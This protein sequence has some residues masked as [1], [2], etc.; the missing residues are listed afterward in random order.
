MNA[1]SRV[2]RIAAAVLVDSAGRVLLVR[3]RGTTTWMQPG[4]KIEPD[5]HPADTI[6][7]EL[8]EELGLELDRENLEYWG[9][10]AADAANEADH[11]VDAEC[12]FVVSD[13]P[14]AV[15][16]E[17]EELLW[18]TLPAAAGLPVAPLSTQHL[19]P[20]LEARG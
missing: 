7:R 6:V 20:L 18:I 2:I 12:Y 1:E 17:I 10:F 14:V 8:R 16:A 11:T 19:F 15:Q 3:K 13:A 5:E 9:R 4:G